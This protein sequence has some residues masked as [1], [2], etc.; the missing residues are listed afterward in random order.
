[1]KTIAIR[2]DGSTSIGMGHVMSCLAVAEKLCFYGFKPYFIMRNYP[3]AVQKVMRMGYPVE[4][5]TITATEEESFLQ[6]VE[7]MKHK[8][9]SILITDLLVIEQ[10]YSRLLKENNI[11]C[12]SIDILGKISLHSDIIINRTTLRSRIASYKKNK[13]TEYYL[14]P[15]YVTLSSSYQGMK[16][17]SRTINPEFRHVLVCMGGGDEFNISSR[18]CR[19]LDEL[20]SLKVT[21]VL[22]AAFKGDIAVSDFSRPP[23]I[24]NDTS[25]MADL[26]LQ[27]DVAI[28]GGGSILYELAIT[29]T[30]GLVIPMNEHQRENAQEFSQFGSVI[31]TGLHSDVTDENIKRH[32]I[33]LSDVELRKKMSAAGKMVTDG[34]GASRIAG[35]VYGV[36]QRF[37]GTQNI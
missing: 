2:V 17:V 27:T 35:I 14:G 20:P 29:G 5:I 32:I 23:K 33:T 15:H 13:S 36:S 12:V 1:M 22:G 16:D 11:A 24:I 18:V 37:N 26:L 30:P 8:G 34:Y 28:T 31:T 21:V 10:D 25:A 6:S 9:T 3:E 7:I 19:I 4:T